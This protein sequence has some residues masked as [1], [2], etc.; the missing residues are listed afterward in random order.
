VEAA[1]W[2]VEEKTKASLSCVENPSK[3]D[4]PTLAFANV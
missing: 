4:P 1:S 2:L 3:A